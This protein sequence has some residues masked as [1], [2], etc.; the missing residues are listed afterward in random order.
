MA[1]CSYTSLAHVFDYK[2]YCWIL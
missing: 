1:L 2:R